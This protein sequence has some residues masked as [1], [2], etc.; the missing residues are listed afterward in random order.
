MNPPST[1]NTGMNRMM[2]RNIFS[3]FLKAKIEKK[4]KRSATIKLQKLTYIQSLKST[5]YYDKLLF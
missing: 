1:D 4:F 3:F 2:I 5:K